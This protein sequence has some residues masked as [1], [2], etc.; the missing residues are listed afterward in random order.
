MTAESERWQEAERAW[1]RLAGWLRDMPSAQAGLLADRDQALRALADIGVLRRLLDQMEFEAVRT[2]RRH[3]RS[4]AEIAVRLGVARQSA[5]ERWRDVDDAESPKPTD[6]HSGSTQVSAPSARRRRASS[7]AV[8]N[9]IGM[10]WH[11]AWRALRGA[12]LVGVGPDPDG[13]P[14]SEL[15]W[16]DGVVTDQSPESGAKVPRGSAVRLWLDRG[17]GSGVREPRRPPPDPK[18]ALKMRDETADEAV[19]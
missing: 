11:Q 3:G 17:G 18:P 19:G 6:P 2:S 10:S 13:A 7:V 16:P 1:E 9:V 14:L 5:W 15:S 4:W 8:P 12:G